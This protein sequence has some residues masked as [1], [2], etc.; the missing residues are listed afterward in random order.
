MAK[1]NKN[2]I[3]K[4]ARMAKDSYEMYFWIDDKKIFETIKATSMSE[5]VAIRAKRIQEIKSG[6][7]IK[8]T[9]INVIE[10]YDIFRENYLVPNSSAI[11]L[12]DYDV[13]FKRYL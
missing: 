11:T 3:R 2:G 10:F 5:A 1:L 13:K 9:D 8:R 7:Y 12:N 4:T 6:E